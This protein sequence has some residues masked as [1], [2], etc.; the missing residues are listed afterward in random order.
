MSYVV[1]ERE[2]T[3]RIDRLNGGPRDRTAFGTMAAARAAR[4]RFLRAQLVYGAD[5]ILI[6][7][8]DEFYNSIEKTETG[9]SALDGRTPVTVRANVDYCCDPRRERYWSM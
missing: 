2:S 5:D 8:S 6:A 9:V 3:R 4:T 1:Y 7:E